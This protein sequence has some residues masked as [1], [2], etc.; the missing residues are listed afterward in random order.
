MADEPTVP[1]RRSSTPGSYVLVSD[2]MDLWDG[3]REELQRSED[4][5][6]GAIDAVR[7]EVNASAV[8]HEQ[9]HGL[10]KRERDEAFARYNAYLKA[11]EINQAVKGRLLGYFRFFLD[12]GGRNW[13]LVATVVLGILGASGHISVGVGL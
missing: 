4:R 12:V 1:I 8:V 9:E 13:K 2:L 10:E 5:M 3:L 6:T 11:E 7:H